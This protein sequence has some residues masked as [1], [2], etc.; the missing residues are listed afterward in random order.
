[1]VLV[2]KS[3]EFI[4]LSKKK[5]NIEQNENIFFDIFKEIIKEQT[6][7]QKTRKIV[8][9]YFKEFRSN[10]SNKNYKNN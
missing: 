8:L 3:N 6:I 7:L 10:I 5:Q 2:V 4:F 1:M 9:S